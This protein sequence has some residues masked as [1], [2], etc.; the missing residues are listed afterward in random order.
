MI[1]NRKML[2]VSTQLHKDVNELA[3]NV[4]LPMTVV[5]ETLMHNSDDIDWETAKRD[6]EHRK[7]TWQNIRRIVQEYQAKYPDVDD[8]KLSELTGFS[9]AQ[10][11]TATHSAH[12]RCIACMQQNPRYKDKQV[13]EECKVSPAFATRIYKQFHEGA[14]VP[15]AEKYLFNIDYSQD[16]CTA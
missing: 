3:E 14:K 6:Y 10:V 11:E 16:R 7:P 13:A 2:G 15:K 5:I 9:V 1:K 4:G 12:K 8:A